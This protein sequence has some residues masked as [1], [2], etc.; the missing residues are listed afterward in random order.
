MIVK[1]TNGQGSWSYF[2][3]DIIHSKRGDICPNGKSEFDLELLDPHPL[4]N[5]DGSRNVTFLNL[6]RNKIPSRTIVTDRVIYILND[7][8]KT[9][10]KI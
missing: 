1:I 10:D 6:E 8:G 3:C 4:L 7:Q 9:I 2:E 5:G